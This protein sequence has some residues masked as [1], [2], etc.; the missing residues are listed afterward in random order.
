[1]AGFK[2]NKFTGLR[3]RVPDPL[4]AEYEATIAHNCD[5]AYGELRMRKYEVYAQPTAE[6]KI[7]RRDAI[8]QAIADV[9]QEVA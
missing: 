5:F 3:P 9:L 6:D 2:L 7:A 8:L 4:L 1:M